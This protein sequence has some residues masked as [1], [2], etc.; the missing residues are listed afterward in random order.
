MPGFPPEMSSGSILCPLSSSNT[1]LHPL[2]FSPPRCSRWPMWQ[3]AQDALLSCSA[4]SRWRAPSTRRRSR[5]QRLATPRRRNVSGRAR[6]P[7]NSSST[8]RSAAPCLRRSSGRPRHLR[9]CAARRRAHERGLRGPRV[10][11]KGAAGA[12]RPRL[13]PTS[14]DGA[15]RC[16]E[17]DAPPPVRRHALPAQRRSASA[18][19]KRMRS[20]RQR[21]ALPCAQRRCG[22][23]CGCARSTRERCRTRSTSPR[24]PTIIFSLVEISMP[25]LLFI[26]P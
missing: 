10:G 6:R 2:T 5:R 12:H 11:D 25:H 1:P 22:G 7:Q 23:P 13:T 19:S 9:S 8:R 16:A 14:G 24:R 3:L 17:L 20:A 21:R 18:R 26:A 15:R 4:R